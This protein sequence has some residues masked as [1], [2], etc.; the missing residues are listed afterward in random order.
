M[1]A[2]APTPYREAAP[3]DELQARQLA[4]L[5]KQRED[6]IRWAAE[7]IQQHIGWVL[8]RIEGGSA[9]SVGHYAAGI[10]ADAHEIV[11]CIAALDAAAET[12][13][14]YDAYCEPP[15]RKEG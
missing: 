8:S 10:A 9:G 4:I 12:A 5:R 7:R 6:K 14:I 13:G 15:V 1:S 3:M 2:P 11:A